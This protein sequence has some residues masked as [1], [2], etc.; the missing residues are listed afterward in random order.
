L[1]QPHVAE[2]NQWREK[3]LMLKKKLKT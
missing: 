1:Q 2:Q 3:E